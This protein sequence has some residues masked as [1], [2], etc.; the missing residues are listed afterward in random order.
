MLMPGLEQKFARQVK[1]TDGGVLV[2]VAQ[3]IGELQ[4]AAQMMGELET[5]SLFHTEDLD[6]KPA[7]S[8]G[9][10]VAIKIE[11]GE[12]GGDDVGGDIHIHSVDDGQE[13]LQP[14]DGSARLSR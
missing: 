12:I 10:A 7:D 9:H 3:D 2:Q 5:R 4:G 14:Q 13:I 8:A 1:P 11:G 6:G